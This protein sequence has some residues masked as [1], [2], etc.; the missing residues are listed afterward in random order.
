MPHFT[1][2]SCGTRLY[3]AAR[4]A[5]LTDPSCPSCG[6]SFAAQREVDHW[7]DEGGGLTVAAP[8]ATRLEQ[9]L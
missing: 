1:C 8:V 5:N 6:A 9:W 2:E 3:S 7:D 4:S